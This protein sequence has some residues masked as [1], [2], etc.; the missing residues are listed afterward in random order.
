VKYPQENVQKIKGTMKRKIFN[1]SDSSGSSS[2][3]E[4]ELKENVHITGKKN[5]KG[6]DFDH[7]SKELVNWE[8]PARIQTLSLHGSDGQVT[9]D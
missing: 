4:G 3:G 9:S 2:S 1:L 6:P 8:H 7:S 5:G